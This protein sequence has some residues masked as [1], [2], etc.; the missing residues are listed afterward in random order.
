MLV[1]SCSPKSTTSISKTSQNDYWKYYEIANTARDFRDAENYEEAA[2]TFL[3]AFRTVKRPLSTD[4]RKI[5]HVYNKLDKYEQVKFYAEQLAEIYGSYP[6]ARLLEDEELVNKLKPELESIVE[7][8]K[9]NFDT[10][11]LNTIR[12]LFDKYRS[13]RKTGEVVYPAGVNV[14]SIN[15]YELLEEI[16]KRGFPS[17]EK[18]GYRGYRNAQ[19]IFLHADF[20]IDNKLLGDF[21]LKAVGRGEMSP[22]DYAT[23]IDK[24]CASKNIPLVYHQMPFGYEDI[25]EAEKVKIRTERKRIGLRSIEKSLKTITFPN[26]DIST[27]MLD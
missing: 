19:R 6:S 16:K 4:L 11:Y 22:V 25:S 8:T 7:K 9:S 27:I 10:D 17:K 2:K 13:V 14:D 21:L 20:D 18:V 3:E 23:I 26:G 1:V 24:R 12:V 15:T 5:M